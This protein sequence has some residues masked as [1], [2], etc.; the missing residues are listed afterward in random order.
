MITGRVSSLLYCPN[1]THAMIP[2][3][4]PCSRLFNRIRPSW[5]EAPPPT[6]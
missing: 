4:Y 6:S 2:H 5:S 1:E 3:F